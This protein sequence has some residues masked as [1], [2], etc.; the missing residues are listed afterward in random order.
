MRVEWRTYQGG[1]RARTQDE[2]LANAFRHELRRRVWALNLATEAR[3]APF[4]VLLT[5]IPPDKLRTIELPLDSPTRRLTPR[6]WGDAVAAYSAARDLADAGG[7]RERVDALFESLLG[8]R[9]A[10]SAAGGGRGVRAVD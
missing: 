6:D 2:G 1:I 8:A 3:K 4:A 7:R 5:T 9:G 10:P